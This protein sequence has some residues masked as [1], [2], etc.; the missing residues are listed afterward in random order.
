M[1]NFFIHTCHP[2]RHAAEAYIIHCEIQRKEGF[3]MDELKRAVIAH[4]EMLSEEEIYILY[5]L[6]REMARKK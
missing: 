2:R 4:L 3:A 1:E 6:I 5:L